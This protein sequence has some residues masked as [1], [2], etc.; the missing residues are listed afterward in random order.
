MLQTIPLHPESSLQPSLHSPGK[1]VV[2]HH[3]VSA[4]SSSVM[5]PGSS[6]VVVVVV[7]GVVLGVVEEGGWE[8]VVSV[9][10]IIPSA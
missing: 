9:K 4:Q 6:V 10:H 1:T 3:S 7:L 8:V 2:S 5:H